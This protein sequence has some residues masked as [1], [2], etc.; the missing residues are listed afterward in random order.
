ML[1]NIDYIAIRWLHRNEIAGMQQH[2]C[3]SQILYNKMTAKQCPLNPMTVLFNTCS[4]VPR[5]PHNYATHGLCKSDNFNPVSTDCILDTSIYNLIL[6]QQPRSFGKTM[7]FTWTRCSRTLLN[8]FEFHF[9][10]WS[11][12]ACIIVCDKQ[13]LGNISNFQVFAHLSYWSVSLLFIDI[14]TFWAY[15][16]SF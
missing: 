1:Q 13:A 8:M 3:V 9:A 15:G 11:G 4:L 14:K 2:K 5:K 6:M 16:V 7:R 12:C 10:F